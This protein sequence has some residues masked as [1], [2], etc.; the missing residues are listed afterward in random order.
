MTPAEIICQF[1]EPKPSMPPWK[2]LGRSALGWW[3]AS[4]D[5]DDAF[6]LPRQLDLGLLWEVED[7]LTDEQWWKYEST[8]AGSG[9]AVR[10]LLEM[11]K[12]H[13]HATPAQKMAALAKVLAPAKTP[14]LS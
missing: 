5:E 8:L 4:S 13:I 11:V 12:A 14:L 3:V 9:A 2:L 7:R 6:W 10:P 1:M